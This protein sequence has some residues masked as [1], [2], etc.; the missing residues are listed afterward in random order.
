MA[1]TFWVYLK[2]LA[3]GSQYYWG[4]GTMFS[5]GN[6]LTDYIT[7]SCKLTT[8]YSSADFTWEPQSS[9]VEDYEM[10]LYVLESANQ[11]IVAAYT[12]QPLGATGS[13]FPTNDGVI[14]EIYLDAMQG[15]PDLARYIANAAYHEL[16]HNK[17]DAYLDPKT[18]PLRDIHTQGGGGLAT[19]GKITANHRPSPQNIALLAKFLDKVHPQYTASSLTMST[20]NTGFKP[21]GMASASPYP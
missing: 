19:G 9:S 11:S 14:A 15:N 7:E 2:N 10:V 5:V 18:A 12:S 3:P 6:M 17:L 4:E 20:S 21:K 8:K 16:L 13:T 1:D